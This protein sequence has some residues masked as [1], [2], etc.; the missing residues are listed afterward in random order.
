VI[1]IGGNLALTIVLVAYGLY[2]AWCR[3]L[4]RDK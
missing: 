4:E 1:E 2:L 3:W